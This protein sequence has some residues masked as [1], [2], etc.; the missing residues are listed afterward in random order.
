VVSRLAGAGVQIVDEIDVI[1]GGTAIIP[2]HGRSPSDIEKLRQRGVA[3]VDATC[4]H[5][6]VPQK[7]VADMAD[8][9][10]VIVFLGDRAHPEVRAVPS[11]AG[12]SR[13]IFV[14]DVSRLPS[15]EGVKRAGVVAQ[16]TQSGEA[17]SALVAEIRN[18]VADVAVKDTICSATRQRQ[19]E[20]GELSRQVDAMV[21]IGGRSSANTKRLAD[22]SGRNC[23]VTL[24]IESASEL[25]ASMLKGAGTVGVTAG[26]STPEWVIAEVVDRLKGFCR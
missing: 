9:G 10:R 21:V 11:Y 19:R 15:L 26:A 14:K 2:A 8:Q 13:V 16:T 18:R 20:A 24:L 5:V 25:D 7:A 17:F 3:I 22:I 4:P 12:G 6:V 23:A 1:S